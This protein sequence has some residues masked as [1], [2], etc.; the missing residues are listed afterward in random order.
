[1]ARGGRSSRCCR[2]D[3]AGTP[4]ED[5]RVIGGIMHMLTPGNGAD[6]SAESHVLA[7]VPAPSQ[8]IAK[9]YDAESL[10]DWLGAHGGK[11]VILPSDP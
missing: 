11:A 10:T 1:M 3:G 2:A 4:R 6:I 9:I 8:L 5:K 7:K